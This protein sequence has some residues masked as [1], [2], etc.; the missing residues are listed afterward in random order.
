MNDFENKQCP[1][2]NSNCLVEK[3]GL[4][5]ERLSNCGFRLIYI[6]LFKLDRTLNNMGPETNQPES[7]AFPFPRRK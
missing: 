2:F 1:L 3:C 7:P 6:N 4:Y 5:D